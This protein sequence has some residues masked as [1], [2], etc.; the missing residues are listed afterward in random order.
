MAATGEP[1]PRPPNPWQMLRAIVEWMQR[2]MRRRAWRHPATR[3]TSRT[4]PIFNKRRTVVPH[5]SID[6]ALLAANE[7]R[8]LLLRA[9]GGESAWRFPAEQ[10]PSLFERYREVG[11]VELN[12]REAS[13]RSYWLRKELDSTALLLIGRVCDTVTCIVLDI[14]ARTGTGFEFSWKRIAPVVSLQR[15][16]RRRT[17]YRHDRY[18]YRALISSRSPDIFEDHLKSI[19]PSWFGIG[20][21]VERKEPPI[22]LGL[23]NLP[24][25]M[26]GQIGGILSIGNTDFGVTCGHVVAR[27]TCCSAVYVESYEADMSAPDLALVSVN[28][29]GCFDIPH[30][31]REIPWFSLDYEERFSPER[32]LGTRVTLCRNQGKSRTGIIESYTPAFSHFGPCIVPSFVV[33]REQRNR[34]IAWPPFG[35]K[36]SKEGDSGSWIVDRETGMWYGMIVSGRKCQSY[37]HIPE[38]LVLAARTKLSTTGQVVARVG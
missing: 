4:R 35:G 34:I 13:D 20:I 7:R 24:G 36:F 5:S 38:A 32:A 33:R 3:R 19:P 28:N 30:R 8:N 15:L 23:C 17:L 10:P 25:G 18:P 21:E 29:Q 31:T 2:V 22:P 12:P 1:P 11:P 16:P 27:P 37:A 6:G 14:A 9:L 26:Y